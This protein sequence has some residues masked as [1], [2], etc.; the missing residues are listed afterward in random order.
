MPATTDKGAR[1]V[2]E[3]EVLKDVVTSNHVGPISFLLSALAVLGLWKRQDRIARRQDEFVRREV[4][5]VIHTGIEG[6]LEEIREDIT[7]LGTEIKATIAEQ[8]RD[9]KA[10]FKRNGFGE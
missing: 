8:N 9:I 10:L 5:N 1:K 2:S 7:N 4:C 3:W 6:R